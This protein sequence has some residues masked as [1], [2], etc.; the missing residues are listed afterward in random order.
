MT[1]TN[2]DERHIGLLKDCIGR[3]E[4][5][6]FIFKDEGGVV[7]IVYSHDTYGD[8][9]KEVEKILYAKLKKKNDK[10]YD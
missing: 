10:R 2:E 1:L 6:Y 5:Y 4:D 9:Q 7:Q 8:F 3:G